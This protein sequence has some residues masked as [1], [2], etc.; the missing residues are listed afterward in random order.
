MDALDWRGRPPVT[1]KA[2][3]ARDRRY[4]ALLERCRQLGVDVLLV[5]HNSGAHLMTWAHPGGKVVSSF[6]KSNEWP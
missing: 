1:G 6:Q 4:E 3:E 2:E 5:A